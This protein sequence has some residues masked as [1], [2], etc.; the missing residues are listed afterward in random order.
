MF[1]L[2][3]FLVL[4]VGILYVSRASLRAP[5]SHGFYRFFAW[6]FIAALFLLNVD[7]W[8]RDPFFW[9]QLISWFL[10]LV[11]LIPLAFGVHS[12]TSLFCQSVVK[13]ISRAA[14]AFR[15]LGGFCASLK[16]GDLALAGSF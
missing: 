7:I 10:L 8:F 11:S 6:E 15:F 9:H 12:L 2:A 5:G 3:A 4:S 1:K 16:T 13:M 14:G